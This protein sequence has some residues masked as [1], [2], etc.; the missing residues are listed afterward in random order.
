MLSKHRHCLIVYEFVFSIINDKIIESFGRIKSVLLVSFLIHY[1]LT[2]L[3]VLVRVFIKAQKSREI[4]LGRY[5]IIATNSQYSF[6]EILVCEY[7]SS[8]SLSM[9]NFHHLNCSRIICSKQ[10]LYYCSDTNFYVVFLH[11]VS[12]K[13]SSGMLFHS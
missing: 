4:F 12:N 8:L 6:S 5:I 1:S 3:I 13:K 11:L 10:C 2:A 7:M 9:G